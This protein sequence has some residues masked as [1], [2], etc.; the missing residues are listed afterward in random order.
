[1]HAWTLTTQVEWEVAADAEASDVDEEHGSDGRLSSNGGDN[2]ADLTGSDDDDDD[3]S[4]G[5]SGSSDGGLPKLALHVCGRLW[6]PLGCMRPLL[7]P[8]GYFAFSHFL[9]H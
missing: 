8:F 9:H 6:T 3:A 2:G 1:M 4:S 5:R 7:K